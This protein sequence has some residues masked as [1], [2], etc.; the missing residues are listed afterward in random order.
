MLA[1]IRNAG[2]MV[3]SEFYAETAF[4]R[5]INVF[6]HCGVIPRLLAATTSMLLVIGPINLVIGPMNSVR[7]MQPPDSTGTAQTT[8]AA[9]GRVFDL[10][11]WKLTLPVDKNGREGGHA[12]EVSAMQLAAGFSNS[13]FHLGGDQSMVFWS[14]VT[15]A[16]TDGTRF[17]RC[18]LREMLAPTDTSV[19]WTAKGTHSLSARCRVLQV[20]GSQ[21]VIVGQ[22]HGYSGQAKPLIKLQFFKGRIE[23]LIKT[24][25]DPK[26]DTD[27][28]FTWP[29]VGL[30]RDF[31]YVIK[32]QDN[33]LSVTV[34]GVTQTTDIAQN[35]PDWLQET[36]YFK[37]G[38]YTQDNDGP[39]TEGARVAFSSFAV[40][41]D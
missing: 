39:A 16:T 11:H 4:M 23:A 7:A 25:P 2:E 28:K 26:N 27:I 29:K 41:H 10:S 37:L 17:P 19:N 40:S 38:A 5:G 14:P 22:I 8:D 32:L 13:Y 9:P 31:D 3:S 6:E 24:S 36:F 1:Y 18:E 30:D 12:A 35:D 34:D 21:K 33:Q 20:P 15:G